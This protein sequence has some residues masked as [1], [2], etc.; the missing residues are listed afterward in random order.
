MTTKLQQQLFDLLWDDDTAQAAN[1]AVAMCSTERRRDHALWIA[2]ACQKAGAVN[3]LLDTGTSIR[4]RLGAIS[5]ICSGLI[6][7]GT[8]KKKKKTT[9]LITLTPYMVLAPNDRFWE[10]TDLAAGNYL[11][12]G[13]EATGLLKLIPVLLDGVPSEY[14]I[15]FIGNLGA[16]TSKAI[17]KAQAML[18]SE[19]ERRMLVE[20]VS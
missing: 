4:G 6:M 19:I 8:F 2:V 9:D 18:Q 12:K 10:E 11:S 1:Q 7:S 5:I 3:A 13:G 16:A 20:V 17:R 14:L 15:A